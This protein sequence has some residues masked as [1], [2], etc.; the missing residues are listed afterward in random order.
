MRDIVQD[1]IN[2]MGRRLKKMLLEVKN[3]SK[4]YTSGMIRNRTV[5]AANDVSFSIRE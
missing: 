5:E 3:L 1:A 4:K 2:V